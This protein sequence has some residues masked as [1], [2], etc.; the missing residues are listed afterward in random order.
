[1]SGERTSD[2]CMSQE[3]SP[4]TRFTKSNH[5]GVGVCV[6]TTT[7]VA[8]PL[9]SEGSVCRGSQAVLVRRVFLI[10]Q[11]VLGNSEMHCY[12]QI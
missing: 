10:V 3:Q 1:M 12:D 7:T 8:R 4:N 9:C 2:T 11:E 6:R 5:D